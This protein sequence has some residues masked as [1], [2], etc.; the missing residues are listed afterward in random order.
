MKACVD[1]KVDIISLSYG[2]QEFGVHGNFNQHVSKLIQDHG[3]IFVTSA[4]NDGPCYHTG[5]YV[6]F[7]AK[8][9]PL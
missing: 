8:R 9:Q 4:G 6:C 7:A 2:E 1:H 5:E 3:I